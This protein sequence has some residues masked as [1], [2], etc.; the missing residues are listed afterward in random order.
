MKNWAVAN[1]RPFSVSDKL[2]QFPFP[3]HSLSQA[4]WF[5]SGGALNY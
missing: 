1:D 5:A 2:L 3:M 4:N